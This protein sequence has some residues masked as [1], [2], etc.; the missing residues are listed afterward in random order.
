[1]K[2]KVGKRKVIHTVTL[3]VPSGEEAWIEFN[4][5]NWNIR[6]KILF[7]VTSD[8]SKQREINIKATDD[9][10]IIIFKNWTNSLGTATRVPVEF[11]KTSNGRDLLFMASHSLIGD[12]NKLDLQFLL[13]SE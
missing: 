11:G 1:M 2:L 4:L 5:D 7:E 12:V 13:G 9:Y 3:I 8:K 6:L 10:G